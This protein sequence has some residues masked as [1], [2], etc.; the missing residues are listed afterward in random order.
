MLWGWL[1]W[2]DAVVPV[3]SPTDKL[4]MTR[5]C[6]GLSC[7]TQKKE[8]YGLFYV[9]EA[10]KVS[11]LTEGMAQDRRHIGLAMRRSRVDADMHGPSRLRRELDLIACT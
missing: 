4:N 7:R 10:L 5:K 9:F 3:F 6:K 11:Q 2:T 8:V 1:R